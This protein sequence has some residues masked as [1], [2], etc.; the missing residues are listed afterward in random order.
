LF[1]DSMMWKSSFLVNTDSKEQMALLRA[2][3]QWK[4]SFSNNF[5]VT[6][7]L[8]GSFLTLNSTW[9]LEPRAGFDWFIGNRHSIN[10]GTGLYSQIQ[11]HVIYY[12][13]AFQPGGSAVQPNLD[14]DFTRSWQKEVGYNYLLTENLRFKAETYYQYIYDVPVKRS[15]PQYALLNQGHEF[16]FDRQ[17]A[18]SLLNLGSGENYGIEFTFERFFKKNYY[19]LLTSSLF[20]STYRGYDAIQRNSAFDVNYVFNAVGDYEFVVGKRKWGVLSFGL[21]T[22]F[23]GGNPY[24]PYNVDATV[25]YGEPIP[26][27]ERSYEARYPLY[28]RL[29]LRIGIKRNLP[30]YTIEFLADLQYRTNYTNVALQRIDPKTGEIRYFFKMGFFPIGTWR[31]Q[32]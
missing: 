9:A 16:F 1:A 8:F 24:I 19:F 17:Y 12:L 6:A 13:L 21:R 25:A 2:Y 32:F 5:S 10:F 3:S 31:L 30:A 7:G 20:S 18:D 27:W 22:T 29:C 26:D 23:A 14:L 4:H 28:K 15:I 11:P